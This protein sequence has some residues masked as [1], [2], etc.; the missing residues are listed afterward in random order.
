MGDFQ[1]HTGLDGRRPL[2]GRLR[3]I[4]GIAPSRHFYSIMTTVTTV[5][6]AFREPQ[7]LNSHTHERNSE[8]LVHERTSCYCPFHFGRTV[9]DL[10]ST[11]KHVLNYLLNVWFSTVL[12]YVPPQSK[13]AE[14]HDTMY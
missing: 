6:S 4:Q 8:I 13:V 11:I 9:R 3:F 1:R 5:V 14:E 12:Q 7:E 2:V 10:L